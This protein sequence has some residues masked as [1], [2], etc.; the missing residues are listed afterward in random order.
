MLNTPLNLKLSNM[1]LD[2]LAVILNH[3]LTII[4]SKARK[5]IMEELDKDKFNVNNY[6]VRLRD[7]G[8]LIVRPADKNLYVNP[9]IIEIVKDKKVTFEF[10]LV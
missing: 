7:K 1:E 3:N 6:I 4:D 5:I 2:F 8:A 10:D 9:N